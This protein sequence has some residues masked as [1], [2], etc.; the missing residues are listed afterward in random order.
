MEIFDKTTDSGPAI[1]HFHLPRRRRNGTG[2]GYEF[3]QAHLAGTEANLGPEINLDGGA[4]EF[5]HRAM[6]AY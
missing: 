6:L 3:Q 5:L 2:F 1:G 4:G